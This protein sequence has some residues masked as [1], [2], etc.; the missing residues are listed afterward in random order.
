MQKELVKKE[1]WLLG[2]FLIYA[3]I[4]FNIAYIGRVTGEVLRGNHPSTILG[5]F[6]LS[7]CG[8]IALLIGL[9]KD[10]KAVA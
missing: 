1:I 9:F 2:S 5:L 6:I 8:T 4:V 7:V 10:R 3:S